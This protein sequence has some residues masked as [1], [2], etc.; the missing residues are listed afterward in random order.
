MI[1]NL[2][3]I[4]SLFCFFLGCS[5]PFDVKE[6]NLK[7]NGTLV[8]SSASRDF[9]GEPYLLGLGDE[10]RIVVYRHSD[11]DRALRIQASGKIFF[12]LVG[13]ITVEGVTTE[14]VR[15][16]ITEGLKEQIN[17]PQVNVEITKFRARKIYIL[18]EVQK[19]TILTIE[20]HMSVMDA[21]LLAGGPTRDADMNNFI[22]IRRYS[23]KILLRR[24]EIESLLKKGDINQIIALQK[25]D[26]IYVPP[27]FIADVDRFFEH[28]AKIIFPIAELERS[29]I[30]GDTIR[31]ILEGGAREQTIFINR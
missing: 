2:I 22:L 9:H 14:E 10:V 30:L 23:D 18:G 5:Y 6:I 28:F 4:V 17:D 24:I 25:D 15:K 13:E 1:K 31:L 3:T 26:I 19:P 7:E 20:D 8:E 21:L 12:P 27:S 16:I 29:I 11:L